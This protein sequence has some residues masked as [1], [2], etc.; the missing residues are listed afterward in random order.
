MNLFNKH[1][2]RVSLYTGVGNWVWVWGH[3]K[4][5]SK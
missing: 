5:A 4:K 1:L 3:E 2:L